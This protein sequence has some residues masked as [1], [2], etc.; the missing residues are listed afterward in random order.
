MNTEKLIEKHLFGKKPEKW[1]D[2]FD[3]IKHLSVNDVRAMLD[4]HAECVLSGVSHSMTGDGMN[5]LEFY[6]MIKKEWCLSEEQYKPFWNDI[7]TFARKYHKE[8][9]EYCG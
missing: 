2:E 3:R 1:D 9:N 6:D 8:R 4:E 7:L 5:C